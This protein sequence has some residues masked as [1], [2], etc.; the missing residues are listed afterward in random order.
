ML[1]QKWNEKP[2]EPDMLSNL[3]FV[4]QREAPVQ[5]CSTVT[6]VRVAPPCPRSVLPMD[7]PLLLPRVGQLYAR[8]P[9]AHEEFSR[10]LGG[11]QTE[12][13]ST[14]RLLGVY[15]RGGANWS[16]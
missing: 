14:G 11:R 4:R 15:V 2:V 3:C 12:P 1:D 8:R 16:V 7:G 10:G 13:S 6:Q 9:L 5:V